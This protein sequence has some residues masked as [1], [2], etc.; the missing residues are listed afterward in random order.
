MHH[1]KAFASLEEAFEPQANAAYAASFLSALYHGLGTWP[2]ATAAYHSQTADIGTD[3]ARRVMAVWG[4]PMPIPVIIMAAAAAGP[5]PV[6]AAF[7][8]AD[9]QYRA[10]APQSAMFG[11]FAN[12]ATTL[13]S[14]RGFSGLPQRAETPKR[15][16]RP[17][18]RSSARHSSPALIAAAESPVHT[19]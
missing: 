1:P 13:T 4:H 17:G 10:F 9:Q 14:L 15:P 16:A 12:P 7:A 6:Y 5:S 19:P 18:V 11:A 2:A 3:Y 8:A